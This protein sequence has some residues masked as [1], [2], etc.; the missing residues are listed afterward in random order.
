LVLCSALPPKHIAP[1]SPTG[2]GIGHANTSLP[3][4]ALFFEVFGAITVVFAVLFFYVVP[5]NQLNARWLTKD[6]R[7]IAVERIRANRTGVENR[8]F[9]P[10]QAVE[11]LLDVTVC[12]FLAVDFH[13][14]DFRAALQT[15]CVF[16]DNVF[17]CAG[18]A[19]P[20]TFGSIIV[21]VGNYFQIQSLSLLT[22]LPGVWIQLAQHD[23]A[24]SHAVVVYTGRQPVGFWVS[25]VQ[26]P[27]FQV[28]S[29]LRCQECI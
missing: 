25:S 19:G 14:P 26:N 9:K 21:Q 6:E 3:K 5:D 24:P 17:S 12:S 23:V 4:W 29:A 27:Q 11:A 1:D 28:F 22:S 8:H 10:Y 15:W 7:Q 18:A 20:G 13:V 16:F 2:Y